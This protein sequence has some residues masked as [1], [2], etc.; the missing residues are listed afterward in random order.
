[1][2]PGRMHLAMLLIAWCVPV[3]E[4]TDAVRSWERC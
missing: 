4:H 3:E 2:E 1:V